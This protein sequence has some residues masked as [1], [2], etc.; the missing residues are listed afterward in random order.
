MKNP[1]QVFVGSLD[2]ATVH[3]VVQR[4]YIIDEDEKSNMV[5]IIKSTFTDGIQRDVI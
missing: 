3:T 5:N 1:V 2:L 4:L